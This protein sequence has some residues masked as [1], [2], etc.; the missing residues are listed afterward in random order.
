MD[1]RWAVV[2]GAPGRYS[3]T[4]GAD[5]LM[6]AKLASMEWTDTI[7]QKVRQEGGAAL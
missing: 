4:K 3:T 5:K 1:Y 7:C 2:V 6:C